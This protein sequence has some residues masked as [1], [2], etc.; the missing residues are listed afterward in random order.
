MDTKKLLEE[1]EYFF[2]RISNSDYYNRHEQKIGLAG[3]TTLA[4]IVGS[5]IALRTKPAFTTSFIPTVSDTSP[6]IDVSPIVR[7]EIEK[8]LSG[9]KIDPSLIVPRGPMNVPTATVSMSNRWDWTGGPELASMGLFGVAV[10]AIG[11]QLYTYLHSFLRYSVAVKKLERQLK[12]DPSNVELREKLKK[13][14]FKME[15]ARKRAEI[16]ERSSIEKVKEYENRLNVMKKNNAP[17]KEINDLI[18]KIEAKRNA[19][20]RAGVILK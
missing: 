20:K 4:G 11:Y 12:L 1:T 6:N 10:G 5:G 8:T 15:E 13:F 19:L 9:T 7:N 14:T 16:E 2:E 18:S 17:R 3:G